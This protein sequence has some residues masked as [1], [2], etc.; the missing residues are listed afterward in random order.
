MKGIVERMK[1]GFFSALAK[2]KKKPQRVQ[3]G[4][5]VSLVHDGRL[6]RHQRADWAWKGEGTGLQHCLEQDISASCTE[7]R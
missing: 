7:Q 1:I 4:W 6:K 5:F 3:L 2:K